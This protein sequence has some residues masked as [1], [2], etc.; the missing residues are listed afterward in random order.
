MQKIPQIFEN[1]LK[2]NYNAYENIKVNDFCEIQTHA[3]IIK[4]YL[5]RAWYRY[6]YN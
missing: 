2:I 1:I 3:M 5:N 6:L 4:I